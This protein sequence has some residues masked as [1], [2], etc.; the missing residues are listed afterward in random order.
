MHISIHFAATTPKTLPIQPTKG[1]EISE[2]INNLSHDKI[3]SNFNYMLKK[4]LKKNPHI[5]TSVHLT[6]QSNS[7]EGAMEA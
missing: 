6:S 3:P 4:K 5:G 7:A 2:L 1:L